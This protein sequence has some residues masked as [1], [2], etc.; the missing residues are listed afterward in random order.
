MNFVAPRGSNKTAVPMLS[1]ALFK[2][3]SDQKSLRVYVHN[4]GVKAK[5]KP[6]PQ[7]QQQPPKKS[8]SNNRQN[9]TLSYHKKFDHRSKPSLDI[10]LCSFNSKTYAETYINNNCTNF[11]ISQLKSEQIS[12]CNDE[13]SARKTKTAY[14]RTTSVYRQATNQD[15]VPYKS[16]NSGVKR[17]IG[18]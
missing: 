15:D 6:Q 2:Q 3:N 4:S 5:P 9:T 8:S 10:N 17:N 11:D 13:A 18:F 12:L 1:H 14:K 7:P 16:D